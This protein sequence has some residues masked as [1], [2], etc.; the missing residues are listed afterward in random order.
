MKK[1]KRCKLFTLI[2]LLVVIAIIAILAAMLLPALNKARETARQATCLNNHKQWMLSIGS[3]VD[4]FNGYYM[5]Q[6]DRSVKPTPWYFWN[7]I[8]GKYLNLGTE[9]E[10][11]QDIKIGKCPSDQRKGKR[12][13]YGINYHWGYILADGTYQTATL[14]HIKQSQ[15]KRPA[16]LIMTLDSIKANFSSYYT[17]WLDNF[18]VERHGQKVNMSFTDGHAASMK[19]REFGLYNGS[20][21]GW[22]KDNERWK[23]W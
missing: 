14:R 3:Y 17:S 21:D 22:P 10:D 12:Y 19:I 16:Y 9:A 1:I 23:Q 6:V 15:I 2:E 7:M 13:S 11:Y 18:D 4:D 20:Q 8:L 5:V